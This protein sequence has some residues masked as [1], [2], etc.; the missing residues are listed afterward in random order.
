MADACVYMSKVE[1]IKILESTKKPNTTQNS[2]QQ[3][4]MYV[5]YDVIPFKVNGDRCRRWMQMTDAGD[6]CNAYV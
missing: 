5:C 2:F 4:M 1:N 3:R 6:G